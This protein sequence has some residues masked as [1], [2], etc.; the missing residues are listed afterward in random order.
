M[1]A[2]A[3]APTQAGPRRSR[4]PFSP[5]LFDGQVAI[6]TGG[7]TGIGLAT[8]RA[9]LEL[10]ARVALCG[11]TEVRV[12]GASA[13]LAME[14]GD[15]AIGF[16]CDIRDAAQVAQFVTRTLESFGT[17]DVLVNNAGVSSRHPRRQSRAAASRR[18]C[19]TTSSARST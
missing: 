17:I 6:V 15:R 18:S 8:A 2:V 9:L 12:I 4:G 13:A 11:R 14:F 19:V 10:G 7:A 3:D 16:P 5:G 1:S